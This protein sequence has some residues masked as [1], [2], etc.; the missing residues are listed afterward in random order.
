MRP[1]GESYRGAEELK[2]FILI[3]AAVAIAAALASIPGE[4]E[5]GQWCGPAGNRISWAIRDRTLFRNFSNACSTHDV[6]YRTRGKKSYC[7]KQFRTNMRNH[8]KQRYR[9]IRPL[10]LK[11]YLDAD[12]YYIAVKLFARR[13]YER[14]RGR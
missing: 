5:A 2:R 7:D 13:A 12:K 9:R 8:C 11:C 3:T 14:A 4:A 6:C 1:T 10:R